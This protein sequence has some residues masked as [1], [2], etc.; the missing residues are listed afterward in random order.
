MGAGWFGNPMCLAMLC[1]SFSNVCFVSVVPK[2]R[3][4][5]EAERGRARVERNTPSRGAVPPHGFESDAG[6]DSTLIM[7]LI[8]PLTVVLTLILI[9]TLVLTLTLTLTWVL[10]VT[11]ALTQT[12]TPTTRWTVTLSITFLLTLSLARPLILTLILT[13]PLTLTLTTTD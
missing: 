2:E 5:R 10:M 7:I 11:V 9:L 6:Y 3:E 1:L 12:L 13:L 4:G 8:L